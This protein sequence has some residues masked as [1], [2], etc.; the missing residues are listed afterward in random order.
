MIR[1]RDLLAYL[2]GAGI[3][4]TLLVGPYVLRTAVIWYLPD[5]RVV[6]PPFFVLPIL[7]GL[8]NLLWVRLEPASGIGAWGALLGLVAGLALNGLFVLQGTWFRTALLVPVFLPVLYYLLW[9]LVVGP[10]NDA[11][12]APVSDARSPAPASRRTP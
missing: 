12:M 8:W 9:R 3:A 4:G 7:W 5:A 6:Q 2:V 10:L 11:V 1:R